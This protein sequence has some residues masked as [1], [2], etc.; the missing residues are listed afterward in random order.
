MEQDLKIKEDKGKDFGSLDRISSLEIAEKVR[1]FSELRLFLCLKL[2]ACFRSKSYIFALFTCAA[3]YSI[4]WDEFSVKKS[5]IW[6]VF[7]K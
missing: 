4:L 6:V 2:L 5:V 3:N 7:D 1:L